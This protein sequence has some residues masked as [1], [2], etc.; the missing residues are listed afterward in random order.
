MKSAL[1]P[2]LPALQLA[3]H[4]TDELPDDLFRASVRAGARKVR[5]R[6]TLWSFARADAWCPSRTRCFSLRVHAKSPASATV[7]RCLIAFVRQPISTLLSPRL[8]PA[9]Q[10][11]VN[12][13]GRDP[14]LERIAHGISSHEPLPD[15]YEAATET[16]AG[17]CE[18]F[19]A[20]FGSKGMAGGDGKR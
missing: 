2:L 1:I 3:L 13:W 19:F 14:T 17:V 4:G 8:G 10:I 11:N 20:L 5:E 16:F 15:T 12:S 18:R 9:P 6:E 7:A